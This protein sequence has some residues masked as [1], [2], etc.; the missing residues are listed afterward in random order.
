MWHPFWC[1]GAKEGRCHEE[2]SGRYCRAVEVRH[3]RCEAMDPHTSGRVDIRRS[4]CGVAKSGV[5]DVS[6]TALQDSQ[7]QTS[8]RLLWHRA[9][10]VDTF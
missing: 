2:V 3:H 1:C 6:D 4:Q 9:C 5:I 7:S 8:V 10:G